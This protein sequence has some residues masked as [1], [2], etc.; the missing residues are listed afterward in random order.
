MSAEIETTGRVRIVG[1]NIPFW[2]LVIL[3]VKLSLA[4]VPA[5]AI[6]AVVWLFVGRVLIGI[7]TGGSHGH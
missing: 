3:L 2:D 5:F 7:I 4:A 6:L 1:I